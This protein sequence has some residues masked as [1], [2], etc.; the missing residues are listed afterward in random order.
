M[1]TAANKIEW[2]PYPEER[3]EVEDFYLLTVK[4]PRDSEPYTGKK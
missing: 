3:P 2:H 4:G 1:K